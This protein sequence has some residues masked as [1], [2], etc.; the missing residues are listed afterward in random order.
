MNAAGTR[1][2]TMSGN[3]DQPITLAPSDAVREPWRA[4]HVGQGFAIGVLLALP[5]WAL[6]VGVAW[7]VL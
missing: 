6:I 1:D 2:P 5:L 3:I 7:A 4:E